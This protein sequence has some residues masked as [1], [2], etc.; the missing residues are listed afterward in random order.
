MF[1]Q[2]KTSQNE[3][4]CTVILPAMVSVLW[5]IISFPPILCTSFLQRFQEAG[6]WLANASTKSLKNDSPM[7]R[8]LSQLQPFVPIN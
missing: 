1:G 2:I 5:V 6:S 7:L 8:R 3:V 4:S